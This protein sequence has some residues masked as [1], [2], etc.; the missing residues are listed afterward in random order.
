L[1]TGVDLGVGVALLIGGFTAGD[2]VTVGKK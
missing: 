2:A 1:G